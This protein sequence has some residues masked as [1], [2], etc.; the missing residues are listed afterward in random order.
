MFTAK[1]RKRVEKLERMLKDQEETLH[2][3]VIPLNFSYKRY[4]GIINTIAQL[5]E[6]NINTIA[7]LKEENKKLKAIVAELCDYVYRDSNG[8]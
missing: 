2:G 4:G 7:Q 8:T 5:K 3:S 6:E 1:L